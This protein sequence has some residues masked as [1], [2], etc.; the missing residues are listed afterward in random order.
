MTLVLDGEKTLEIIWM[1]Y[2]PG[3]ES[4]VMLEYTDGRKIE[5][6]A[7]DFEG[8]QRM[9]RR[10]ESE[11]DMVFEGY[12]EVEAVIKNRNRLN[13]VQITMHRPDGQA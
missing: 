7:H 8:V 4:R 10:S 3:D 11:G 6:I 5:D 12:S 13:R 1:Y 9:E 2:V